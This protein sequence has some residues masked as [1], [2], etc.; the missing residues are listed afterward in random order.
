MQPLALQASLKSN[1]E[2]SACLIQIF[3]TKRHFI[4]LK[5]KCWYEKITNSWYCTAVHYRG[6]Y[7]YVVERSV[8]SK[9][10]TFLIPP[11]AHCAPLP[12]FPLSVQG[13][14]L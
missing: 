12:P 9:I 14:F 3:S 5:L 10:I 11:P 2:L 6:A 1:Q 4:F 8:G 13:L 7:F